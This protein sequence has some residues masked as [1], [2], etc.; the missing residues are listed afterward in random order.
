MLVDVLLR[1]CGSVLWSFVSM[2]VCAMF[3]AY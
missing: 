3:P 2:R 1:V